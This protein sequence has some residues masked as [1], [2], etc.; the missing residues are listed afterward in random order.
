MAEE[1]NL[2]LGSD[3]D[4][5]IKKSNKVL[6][7]LEELN[8]GY[9]KFGKSSSAVFNKA[10]QDA[11]KFAQAIKEQS[12]AFNKNSIEIENMK[13]ALG[14]L[15]KRA[16]GD[17]V[18]TRKLQFYRQEINKLEKDIEK[19]GRAGTD[20]FDKFG[21]KLREVKKDGDSFLGSLR[22]IAG[23]IGITFGLSELIQFGKELFKFQTGSGIVSCPIT[24]EEN[25][26]QYI[27][28]AS[29]YG[30]AV[31]LWGGDMAELTKT[32]SQGGSFWVFK[33]KK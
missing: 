24:W 2:P 12:T 16:F 22:N 32:V 29:G 6:S 7:I 20:G 17:D 21:N 31:P 14:D 30:G 13:D 8:K 9:E 3:I 10:S 25:G 26:E 23:A 28:L 15:K 33:I 27:G 18:D 1:Y 4:D 5:I 11:E 19:A